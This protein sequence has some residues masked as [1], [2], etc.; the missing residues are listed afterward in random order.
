MPNGLLQTCAASDSFARAMQYSLVLAM[1]LKMS[2]EMS[3]SDRW[4]FILEYPDGPTRIAEMMALKDQRRRNA[5]TKAKAINP[6]GYNK[7]KVEE[8]FEADEAKGSLDYESDMEELDKEDQ[9]RLR[10]EILKEE[11]EERKERMAD[12]EEEDRI[13]AEEAQYELME[14]MEKEREEAREKA[15]AM[16]KAKKTQKGQTTTT[17]TR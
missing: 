2:Y 11:E 6:K 13:A 17:T 5:H 12:K 3:R 14:Q 1:T 16:E 7:D 9:E 8:E 15:E 10:Q 4:Q